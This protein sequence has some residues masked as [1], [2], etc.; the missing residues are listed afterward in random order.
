LRKQTFHNDNSHNGLRQETIV[1]VLPAVT[2][3]GSEGHFSDISENASQLC[4]NALLTRPF[5]ATSLLRWG[6]TGLMIR[7]AS[8]QEL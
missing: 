7:P 8:R 3:R 5:H 6:V 4:A 1:S 2:V